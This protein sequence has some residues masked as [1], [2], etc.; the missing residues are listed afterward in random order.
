[1]TRLFAKRKKSRALKKTLAV[2]LL[3]FVFASAAFYH[4][5]FAANLTAPRPDT[6]PKNR[7][8]DR[9]TEP[10]GAPLSEEDKP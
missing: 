7:W 1:M 2:G 8:L 10:T 3:V 5:A 9:L 6:K 4:I